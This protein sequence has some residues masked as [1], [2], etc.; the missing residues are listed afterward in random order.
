MKLYSEDNPNE[1]F[2]MERGMTR[3]EIWTFSSPLGIRL[4]ISGPFLQT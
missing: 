2:G 3:P 4:K 1:L